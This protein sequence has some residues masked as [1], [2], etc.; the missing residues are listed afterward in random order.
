MELM[1]HAALEPLRT[2]PVAPDVEVDER[3]ARRALRQQ[4]ARLERELGDAF[5]SAF[6]ATGVDWSVRPRGGPRVLD[7]G[8]LERVR[9]E[10]AE[11][12]STTRADLA[13]RAE[14]QSEKR[15]LLEKML[16]EPGKYK[17]VRI[18]VEEVGE[19]GCG[20][21]HVR[22]RLGVVGMLMGWWQ[23]KLSSGCPLAGGSRL[24]ATPPPRGIH[25][26]WD[27]AVASA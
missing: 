27:V 14:R 26:R 18:K 11:R 25:A 2:H 1:E 12:I 3:A 22:P 24:A 19:R 6:P 4:I 5:V 23:V 13:E 21:Y 20:A 8:D 16:L 7:L 9:D 17:F 10:L 15:V